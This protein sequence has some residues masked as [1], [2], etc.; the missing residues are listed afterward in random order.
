VN[1]FETKVAN[2][3]SGGGYKKRTSKELVEWWSG[4]VDQCIDGYDWTIYEYDDEI[5]VR[6]YLECLLID[7]ELQRFEEYEPFRSAI[8]EVDKRFRTVLQENVERPTDSSYWWR[9]GVL[10]FAGDEYRQDMESRY[11]IPVDGY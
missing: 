4:F 1:N 10:Q 2:V 3:L 7:S 6:D 11:S 5:G 9:R 8:D